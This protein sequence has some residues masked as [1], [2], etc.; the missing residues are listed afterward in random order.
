MKHTAK[1]YAEA[2]F[3]AVS[4][5]DGKDQDKVIE[6]LVEMMKRNQDLP[7]YEQTIAE[8]EKLVAKEQGEMTA[9]VT[10]ASEGTDEKAVID[11]LNKLGAKKVKIEKEVDPN[12]LGGVI[13]RMDDTEIDASIRG[14]LDK[15]KDSMIK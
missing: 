6:N 10:V 12:I 13:I 2:L 15:L 14:S 3:L 5:T 1:Q 4:E 11:S 8:F 9:K 7:L